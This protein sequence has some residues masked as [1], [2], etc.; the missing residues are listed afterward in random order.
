M[1][2]EMLQVLEALE[3]SIRKDS[4]VKPLE[5]R[6]KKAVK[7]YWKAQH[8]A[9][10]KSLNA[11]LRPY[12]AEQ[13]QELSVLLRSWMI[14][15]DAGQEIF[16]S[17]HEDEAVEAIERGV[18]SALEDVLVSISFNVVSQDSIDWA[19]QQ[20]GRLISGINNTTL[21]DIQEIIATGVEQGQSWKT[22]S[23]NISTKFRE[24]GTVADG[25]QYS[26]ADV[27][28]IT[29][30]GEAYEEGRRRAGRA[31]QDKGVLMEKRW[32]T[33]QDERVCPICTLNGE[34][35]WIDFDSN[36]SSGMG[37]P[38]GH[39]TCRCDMELRAKPDDN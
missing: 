35:Y 24:Y 17:A 14:A 19:R 7:K 18:A 36:F 10:M 37:S 11:T 9:L 20:S 38:L 3:R 26:R 8:E 39:P 33:A 16:V 23:K 34:D 5:R 12:F 29:E 32:L 4:D 27:I 6:M 2:V 25:R 30:T 31:L 15:T 22:V 13:A 1:T 21:K 28:A